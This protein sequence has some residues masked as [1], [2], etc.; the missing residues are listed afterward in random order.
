M[1]NSFFRIAKSPS[2]RWWLEALMTCR[3]LLFLGRRH[4]CPCCGWNVR[5]FTHGGTSL[6]VRESGYCPR[7]N[8]KARHRRDWLYLQEKTNL[9]T[10]DIRLLHVSPKYALSRRFV[11]M[12]S[13]K[14]VGADLEGRPNVCVKMDLVSIPFETE[15]FDA[16]ICIHVLEH[17][18][19]DR[20]AI[21]E[22]HRVLKPGGW[23]FISVPIRLDEKTFED[24]AI[25]DPVERRRAFGEEQHVR[26]YGYDLTER[27]EQSGF[28][29]QLDLGN[30]L[31]QQT[32]N[33]YG[34][35][36][37]ENI[38]YCTKT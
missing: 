35:R 19:D 10:S 13:L 24:P 36:E 15:S 25:R 6:K 2:N 5:A 31:D 28:Q 17:V 33:K 20:Q 4:S 30:K 21:R 9:F 26:Y 16:V 7:C 27:L 34:L 29:V 3:A 18:N 11:R 14:Y 12:P 32:R 38:F 22:M 37:D 23:A 1:I 8:S